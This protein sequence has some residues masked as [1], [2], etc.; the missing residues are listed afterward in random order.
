M[1]SPAFLLI[2]APLL[3]LASFVILVFMGKRMGNPLAGYVGT[4]AIG[5]SFVCSLIAMMLWLGGGNF[6]DP[7]LHKSIKYGAGSHPI[8]I[9]V[10]WIPIGEGTDHPEGLNQDH[11]GFLDI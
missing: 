5:G 7:S 3:P 10:K 1:P 6:D 11:P 4:A 8:N 2:L 9:P